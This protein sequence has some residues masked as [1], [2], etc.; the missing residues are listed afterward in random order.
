MKKQIAVC[1][2]S[3]LTAFTLVGCVGHHSDVSESANGAGFDIN[4]D[5]GSTNNIKGGARENY[6]IMPEY[7]M[8][9]EIAGG[10][11]VEPTFNTEEYNANKENSFINVGTQAL[12]TFAMDVDTGAYTNFRRMVRDN[13]T[14]DKIPTGAIRIEEMVNYFDYEVSNNKDGKFNVAYDV[15]ICPWN[16]DN[17]LMRI[18]LQTNKTE[19][20]NVR[21][22]F[23]L[24][25][26]VSGSMDDKDKIELASR[27][28]MKLVDTF[29]E[30]DKVS[31]VTYAGETEL[32]LDGANGTDKSAIEKALKDAE[33]MCTNYGGGTNGSGG[34][35]GAY[36][37]AEKNFIEGG[38]NRVIIASDGD[39]NLGVTSQSGLV[40]L[41]KEKKE[42]GVFLTTLGFGSGNYSDANMEQIAD[43]GN[44]NYYYIDCIEEANRVLVEK[45]KETTVTVAK[46]AKI[47]V[48]FNPTM[49]KQYRLLGYENRV[50]AADDFDDDKKDGGEVGAGQQV[51]VLYELVPADGSKSGKDLKYQETGNL[52][53]KAYSGELCTVSVRYKEPDEDTSVLETFEIL[54]TDK[55]TDDFTFVSAVVEACLVIKK[56]EYKGTATLE[57]AI[58]RAKSAS[59]ENK[60][61]L[62]FVNLIENLR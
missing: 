27:A 20:K 28:F 51:T 41:I 11:F 32:L 38:N 56:S 5:V 50:M 15:G 58:D 6:N 14:L 48:E 12:S 26:D 1:L 24:L 46:D 13:I 37:V 62:E 16:K 10:D 59:N 57:D 60:Y 52:T 34:I 44:G 31:V 19:Q 35:E 40:D 42:K 36:R 9:D 39:M 25:I 43:A 21:N 2:V 53:E 23:V 55:V 18:T 8:T 49:V 22:N 4:T 47:Q 7:D 30:N 33:Y 54:P 3:V 61:R 17:A 29:T 45:L